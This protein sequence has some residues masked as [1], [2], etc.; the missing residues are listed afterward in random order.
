MSKINENNSY[1]N[2]G[3]SSKIIMISKS[4]LSSAND[5]SNYM[6]IYEGNK[7]ITCE[8]GKDKIQKTKLK[9]VFSTLKEKMLKYSNSTGKI[10]L[11][12]QKINIFNKRNKINNISI[13]SEKNNKNNQENNLK[14]I[15]TNNGLIAIENND[16][17][18]KSEK[19]SK[20]DNDDNEEDDSL[21][22]KNLKVIDIEQM[23]N[24]NIND[25][26]NKN[27]ENNVNNNRNLISQ[28]YFKN[29]K[30]SKNK[31]NPIF[32]IYKS[33]EMKK[34]MKQ[35]DKAVKS[36]SDH[37]S[38]I[39]DN[40][41]M[42]NSEKSENKKSII[43]KLNVYKNKK[44]KD[45]SNLITEERKL[46]TEE[47]ENYENINPKP[48]S[49]P[50]YFSKKNTN[51]LPKKSLI[52]YE[53]NYYSCSLCELSYKESI[54]FSPGC[55]RHYLCKRCTKNFYEEKIDDG[56]KKLFCPF[57]QCKKEIN[58]DKL[59]IFISE[60]HYNRLCQNN[61]N[62][63]ENKLIFSRIKTEYNQ[64]NAELY[65]KRHVIDINTNKDLYNYRGA[66]EGFCPFCFEQALFTQTNNYFYRCLNCLTKV[67]KY[68]FK[69][70]NHYHMDMNYPGRCKVFH[71]SNEIIIKKRN[72]CLSFLLELFFVIALYYLTFVGIFFCLRESFYR[73]FSINKKKNFCKYFFT[74][75]FS[76]VIFILFFPIILLLF[77]Y[78]PSITAIFDY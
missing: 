21:D 10:N 50:L 52:K 18:K 62:L 1:N 32:N 78:F 27:N 38:K 51:T 66:E 14:T 73:I 72:G 76:I 22:F 61:P 3:K 24:E 13:N 58:F 36:V 40:I 29:I 77:P 30:N 19:E 2:D 16:K 15:E 26:S 4:R 59:K 37:I 57:M 25:N 23:C 44:K 20:N 49:N 34:T 41:Q 75:F 65:S 5:F 35:S 45:M 53:D 60:K 70:F 6:T 42:I 68:C 11:A 56:I 43:L 17:N 64:E 46:Y 47:E 31:D 67:C 71:R 54:M 28:N 8:L 12:S 33:E 7:K 48:K 63:E 9:K 74:Y 69:E 39:N 55:N